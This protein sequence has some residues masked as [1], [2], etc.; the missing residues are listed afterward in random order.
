MHDQIRALDESAAEYDIRIFVSE[1]S[2]ADPRIRTVGAPGEIL[3]DPHFRRS[4]LV[5]FQYGVH[6]PLF[7]LLLAHLPHQRTLAYFHN[8][9]PAALFADSSPQARA[10]TALSERQIDNLFFCDRVLCNSA[11]SRDGLIARGLAPERVEVL[12]PAVRA[13]PAAGRRGGEGPARLLYVG[14]FVPQK[15]VRE[16]LLAAAAARDAGAPAFELRLAG[17]RRYSD[18]RYL[19]EIAALI[20]QRGLAERVRLLGELSDAALA[21]EYAAAHALVMPSFHEGFCLPVVEALAAGC[22]VIAS[23][24]GNLPALAGPLGTI[25]PAGDIAAWAAALGD[26]ARRLSIPLTQRRYRGVDGEIPIAEYEAAALRRAGLFGLATFRARFAGQAAQLL[27]GA[28]DPA[29]V[30]APGPR[31][32]AAGA[33]RLAALEADLAA[34]RG[35]LGALRNII[36]LE[37]TNRSWLPSIFRAAD[38]GEEAEHGGAARGGDLGVS[39]D[40]RPRAGE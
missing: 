9:T 26:F 4:R 13:Q 24:A 32:P 38:R 1:A 27:E 39:A 28:G 36:D 25:L 3:R 37:R 15:G 23:D 7:D 18:P 19:D 30:V 8:V 2:V 6:Y 22:Y 40:P 31:R 20:A 11:F 12:L 10:L 5:I 34:R 21:G 35:T 29:E 33:D 14:R 17:A 16:L